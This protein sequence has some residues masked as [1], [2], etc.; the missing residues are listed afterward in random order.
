[1]VELNSYLLSMQKYK[2]IIT[3]IL[4]ATAF[5]I[6]YWQPWK[7]FTNSGVIFVLLCE[8]EYESESVWE[9]R[10]KDKKLSEQRLCR[11]NQL[12]TLKL[13]YKV[14]P[15]KQKVV[16][17]SKG[18]GILSSACDIYDRLNFACHEKGISIENGNAYLSFSSHEI[19]VSKWKYMYIKANIFIDKV[20]NKES[21]YRLN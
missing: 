5:I 21:I 8:K 3:L 16:F 18:T 12:S 6:L 13:N 4:I 2:S 11:T 7:I 9:Y 14:F 10:E 20:F 15:N 17:S 19:A 1:M